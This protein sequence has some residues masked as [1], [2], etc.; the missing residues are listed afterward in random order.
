MLSVT[1]DTNIY[2]S[3]LNFGGLP[4][5]FL[6]LAEAGGIFHLSISDAIVAEI[7]RV[8]RGKK[9]RWPEEEIRIAQR[10]ISRFTEHVTAVDT[11]DAVT[12]DPSDNRI[13]ECAMTAQSEYIVSG[14]EHLL[15]LRQYNNA[16]IL[17]VA[18]FMDILQRQAI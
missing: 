16:R 4:R 13:L 15:R 7:G 10:Q 6:S 17:K 9:F 8:L 5:R 12:V 2:I 1:A 3:A 14:D 11:L 18:D